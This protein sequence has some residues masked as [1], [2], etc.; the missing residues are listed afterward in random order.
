MSRFS[1]LAGRLALVVAIGAVAGAARAEDEDVIDYRK[2]IMSSMG[3]Q[4]Q[5]L[6]MMLQNKVPADDFA[7]HAQVLAIV[8]SMARKAFEPEVQGGESKAVVW[9]QWPDFAKR[10]DELAA[11]TQDLA[12][13]AKEGGIAAAGP[14]VK[15]ALT[16]KGCHD[17]YREPKK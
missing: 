7:T 1:R 14:K 16:C 6:G 5:I 17:T 13:T 10:L 2:H 3:E 4:A 15:S 11:A 8:A 12:K 9:A